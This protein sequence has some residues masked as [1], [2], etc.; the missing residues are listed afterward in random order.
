MYAAG[1]TWY[2]PG[3]CAPPTGKHMSV[4]VCVFSVWFLIICSSEPWCV[5]W[6]VPVLVLQSWFQ[7][8]C[9]PWC[10]QIW[11]RQAILGRTHS[12][13]PP[14]MQIIQPI[15]Y[16]NTQILVWNPILYIGLACGPGS[17]HVKPGILAPGFR[18]FIRSFM[19]RFT[20]SM[21]RRRDS[22]YYVRR[23]TGSPLKILDHLYWQTAQN[24]EADLLELLLDFKTTKSTWSHNKINGWG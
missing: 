21:G 7:M 3:E 20:L 16:Q 12:P 14:T 11:S 15:I 10:S 1:S 9:F 24:R 17:G 23:Q 19:L 18:L 6:S 13:S 4:F 8:L 5:W 2:I 22:K